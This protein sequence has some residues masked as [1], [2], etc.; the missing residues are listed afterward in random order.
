MSQI[1]LT[2][3]QMKI[4]RQSKDPVKDCDPTGL[5][6]G[7]V[8]PEITPEFIAEMKRRAAKPGPRY[9]S[10]Q[11]RNHLQPLQEAWDREGPFDQKR[12]MELLEQIRAKENS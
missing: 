12:M 1:V 5:I 9:T 6:L 4:V 2:E 7:T 11:V 3:E 8:D 10:E